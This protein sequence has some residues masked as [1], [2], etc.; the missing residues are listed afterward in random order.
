MNN[1]L[2][3]LIF[4]LI[5]NCSKPKTVLIC[6]DHICVNSKEANQYFEENLSIEVKIIDKNKANE[7]NLVE[8][9]LRNI[10]ENNKKMFVKK[11]KKTNKKIKVLTNDE[12]IKI[13]SEIKKKEKEKKLAKNI[14]K[15]KEIKKNKALKKKKNIFDKVKIKKTKEINRK[16]IDKVV[17]I[18]SVVKK[19]N[20]DEI[21]NFLL[22][23][24]NKKDFPDITIRE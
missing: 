23:Q 10:T 21:S 1:I 20:I 12:M 11:K 24:G 8:L 4:F 3:I 15:K 19:C 13:Q 16:K 17:D 18:C 14:V 7:V 9:N 22:I 5:N 6:G 2:I